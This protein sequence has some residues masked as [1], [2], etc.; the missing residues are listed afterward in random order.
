MLASLLFLFAASPRIAKAQENYSLDIAQDGYVD[1][2]NILNFNYYVISSPAAVVNPS[3]FRDW[4]VTA[5]WNL[6]TD[7]IKF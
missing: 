3:T 1:F 5:V 6:I 4:A 7:L 2:G